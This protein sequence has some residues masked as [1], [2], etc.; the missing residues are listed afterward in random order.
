MLKIPL[1]KYIVLYE[2]IKI[3]FNKF[4]QKINVSKLLEYFCSSKSV[5]DIIARYLYY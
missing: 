3:T 1:K 5:K 2:T 4:S